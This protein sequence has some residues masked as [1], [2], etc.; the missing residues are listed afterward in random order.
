MPACPQR[1]PQQSPRRRPRNQR[2]TWPTRHRTHPAM[3]RVSVRHTTW[4][5]R[6][7]QTCGIHCAEGAHTAAIGARV[8]AVHIGVLH[9]R[10]A[11]VVVAA[12]LRVPR[13]IPSSPLGEGR[14]ISVARG[15]PVTAHILQCRG[16]VSGTRHG[17]AAARKLAVYI[18]QKVH[19][20]PP[21]ALAWGQCTSGSCCVA[22]PRWKIRH[23][24]VSAEV[25]PVTP[26]AMAV[27]SSTHEDHAAEWPASTHVVP[28]S[29][30]KSVGDCVTTIV[31]VILE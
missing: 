29:L 24:C 13:G 14:E 21:S 9:G 5:S 2:R 28:K 6:R 19:T 10:H 15:P 25:A 18:V 1:Y 4:H 30:Q 27:T 22:T 3:S 17:T 31:P 7:T 16:S 20:P 11:E 12:C 26:M 8:G 23:A